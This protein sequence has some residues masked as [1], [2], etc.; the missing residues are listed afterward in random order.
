MEISHEIGQSSRYKLAYNNVV[1]GQVVTFAHSMAL[2]KK[3][4]KYFNF[5]FPFDG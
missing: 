3:A 5:P 1:L 2:I 4:G